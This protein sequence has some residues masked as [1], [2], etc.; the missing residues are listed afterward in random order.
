[1][2]VSSRAFSAEC[3][4]ACASDSLA[5]TLPSCAASSASRCCSASSEARIEALVPST[6]CRRCRSVSSSSSRAASRSSSACRPASSEASVP[7]SAE[8][9]SVAEASAPS[10]SRMS[11]S[12][13]AFS[14]SCASR[15]ASASAGASEMRASASSSNT[16][17]ASRSALRAAMRASAPLS[18]S[19]NSKRRPPCPSARMRSA[20]DRSSAMRC[21]SRRTVPSFTCACT[22]TFIA[23]A[24]NSSAPPV[25]EWSASAGETQTTSAVR[26]FPPSESASSVVSLESLY[27]T[28]FC[29]SPSAFITEP[30]PSREVLMFTASL[31]RTP[32]RSASAPERFTRSEPARSTR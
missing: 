20:S 16:L 3:E 17:F 14:A 7:R 27:G 1:M 10:R 23:R 11:S 15:S 5:F 28:N 32:D 18:C 9:A 6:A 21:A 22:A 29:R 19:C 25:S 2:A 4:A 30:R 13:R 8:S 24:P 26:Q 12:S 31:K